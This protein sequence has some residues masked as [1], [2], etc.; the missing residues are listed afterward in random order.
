MSWKAIDRNKPLAPATELDEAVSGKI[1]ALFPRYETR[2]AVLLPA[3]HIVQDAYGHVPPGLIGS[4]ARLLELA[5]AEVMD[6]ISFYTHFFTEPK[7]EHV[8]TLCRSLTCQL[9]GSDQLEAAVR[10]CTGCQEHGP[11]ISPDGRYS[12]LVEECIAA[13]EGAPCM[14]VGERL[15]KNV[16]PEE[17]A[18]IL[19]D[20]KA[21]EVDVPRVTEFCKP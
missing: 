3:L 2:R 1:S 18:G 11:N 17:V 13:C 16:K 6:T 15:Y 9:M 21:A 14:I 12:V 19:S 4:L 8:I 20:P 10:A 5:P 7:G